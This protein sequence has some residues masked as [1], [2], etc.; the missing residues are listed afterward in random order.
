MQI[1]VKHIHRT[2]NG[3]FMAHKSGVLFAEASSF[4]TMI[5]MALQFDVILNRMSI[6][7]KKQNNEPLKT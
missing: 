2:K 6:I 5:V 4:Q 3:F 7:H 1:Q